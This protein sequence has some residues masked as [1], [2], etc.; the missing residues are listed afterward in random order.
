MVP[1]VSI[2]R[3]LCYYFEQLGNGIIWIAGGICGIF[4]EMFARFLGSETRMTIIVALYGL[5]VLDTIS[6]LVEAIRCHKVSSFKLSAVVLKIISYSIA[7]LATILVSQVAGSDLPFVITCY[8]IILTEMLSIMENTKYW[9]KWSKKLFDFLDKTLG[10]NNDDISIIH[11]SNS[12][13]DNDNSNCHNIDDCKEKKCYNG[14]QKVFV[15]DS[16]QHEDAEVP[17]DVEQ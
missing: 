2:M 14:L 10:L 9:I 12:N 17:K 13:T 4:T 5:V 16:N 6:G 3:A 11:D 15:A 7:V 1:V 8:S